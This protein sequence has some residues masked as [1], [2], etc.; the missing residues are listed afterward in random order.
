MIPL[1]VLDLMMIGEDK[2]FADTL[3]DAAMLARHVEQH[4]YRRYWIAE[5][6]DLPGIAS[7]A[8]TLL[9]Q[10]LAG[11]TSRLRLGS[12]GIMLPNHSPLVVAEQFATL[13]TMFP[14]RIDLGIGRAAGAAGLS[15]RALRGLAPERDFESDIAELADYLQDNGRQPVRGIPG[16]HHVP[17]WLQGPSMFS[18]ELAARLGLPYAFASH[19]APHLLMNAIAYYREN[20]RPSEGLGQAPCDR[21][22]QCLRRRYRGRSRLP[23]QFAFPLGQHAAQGPPLPAAAPAGRLSGDAVRPGKTGLAAG[24]GL[25]R[26]R[27]QDAGR[28]MAV[29]LYQRDGRGR[30]DHRRPYP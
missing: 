30:A 24:D 23:R 20:F 26:C 14:G 10:H 28:T 21:G 17:V 11:V 18:A 19:F 29:Q 4:G 7:S 13:E 9:V 3:A 5:H 16:R 15:V 6:H 2:T 8:T 25:F 1:S 27:Q 22:R 12:G